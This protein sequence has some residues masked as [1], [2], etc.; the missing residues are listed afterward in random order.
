VYKY[1]CYKIKI[2]LSNSNT[3]YSFNSFSISSSTNNEKSFN[4]YFFNFLCTSEI[5]SLSLFLACSILYLICNLIQTS[6]EVQK[7]SHIR[8]DK[9]AVKIFSHLIIEFKAGA[10]IQITSA[11]SFCFQFLASNSLPMYFQG[12]DT[13]ILYNL[14]NKK[15][16]IQE[17]DNHL[18]IK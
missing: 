6:A 14:E 18:V 7:A 9:E 17:K 11:N 3:S 15:S 12:C 4:Q 16:P 10:E 2:I 5:L 1:I 8:T 13:C